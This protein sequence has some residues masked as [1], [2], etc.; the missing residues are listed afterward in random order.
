MTPRVFSS[1]ALVVALFLAALA[2]CRGCDNGIDPLDADFRVDPSTQ[3]I[4]FGRVL[5]GTHV[6]KTVIVLAETRASLTITAAVDTPFQ[7]PASIDIPG[8]GQAEVAVTFVA[9]NGESTGTLVLTGSKRTIEVPLHGTGVRPPNCLPS[10]PCIES[11]YSLEEDR[12]I[13]TQSPDDTACDPGSVCLEQGRCRAGLCLG[14]ARTCDDNNACTNDGCSMLSGCVNTPRTCPAPSDPCKVAACDPVT[15][16]GEAPADDGKICGAVD[17]VSGHFCVAGACQVLP[18]PDG[19]LCSAAVACLPEGRCF[20]QECRRPDAGPWLPRWSATVPGLP[21]TAAPALLGSAGNLFFS[22]CGVPRPAPDAGDD[23]GADAG[24]PD[25]GP[26]DGGLD[27][28]TD[29]AGADDAGVDGGTLDAGEDDGGVCALASWTSSGFDR[30]VVP[31]EFDAVGGPRRLVNLSPRGVLLALDGGLELRTG[32]TGTRID[33]VEVVPSPGGVAVSPDG[34]I[35]LLLDDGTLTTWTASGLVPVLALGGQG[36]LALDVRGTLYAW[37]PDAGVLSRVRVLDD[38]GVAVDA[39]H[40]DAGNGSLIATGVSVVAGG[41]QQIVWLPDGGTSERDLTW[42]SPAGVLQ[43]ALPRGVLASSDSVVVFA[44]RCVFP[45]MSC[46]PAD[47]ETWVR[48][49]DSS[50][51]ALRWETKVLP[52]GAS[53]RIVESA[54]ITYTPGALATLV[55]AD[56]AAQDAGTGAYL[57]IFADGQRDVL[58]PLPPESTHLRGAHFASGRLF[59]FV[60]GADAGVRL[61]AYDLNALPLSFSGWPQAD[62]VEAQRSATP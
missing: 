34:G 57:Q 24:A 37:E 62:G 23:G 35:Q 50:S 12:C 21:S 3:S 54:L 19:F 30:F 42:T 6:T 61:E 8:G 10:G 51:G 2:G 39:L 27:G 4:E 20:Q 13:E 55:E 25:A 28:G 40:P 36:V 9:G 32:M 56:F 7:A 52:A 59:V 49:T 22:T 16:C 15:G 14:V 17:C 41:R 58:C 1:R 38:G 11:N 31:Y 46:L 48:V 29:D 43:D 26:S 53:A 60:D 18:T 44:R 5:E 33:S 45:L 47:E